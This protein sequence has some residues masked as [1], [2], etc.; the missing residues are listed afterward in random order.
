MGRVE[1]SYIPHRMVPVILLVVLRVRLCNA[2]GIED[3]L[4]K[5]LGFV[6]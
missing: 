4:I 2:A 5:R 1:L 3:V 6:T